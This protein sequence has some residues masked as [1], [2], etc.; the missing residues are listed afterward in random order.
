MD[1]LVTTVLG[2]VAPEA[3][4]PTDGHNH[5][6]IEPTAGTDPAAPVLNDESAIRQE[7]MA[8]RAAGGQ[9]RTNTRPFTRSSR[10]GLPGDR[11]RH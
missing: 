6:W 10:G 11:L 5:L 8:Y 2:P 3:L 9:L 4:G 7:L 1:G